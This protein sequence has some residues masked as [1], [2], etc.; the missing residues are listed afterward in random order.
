MSESTSSSLAELSVENQHVM[1]LQVRVGICT[2]AIDAV[3]PID[4]AHSLVFILA[5]VY[6]SIRFLS[7]P[8]SYVR[9]HV[10]V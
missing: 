4:F 7:D 6:S 9:L 1:A 10:Y 5:D 8:D 2:L 3:M